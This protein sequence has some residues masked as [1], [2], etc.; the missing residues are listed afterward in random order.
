[1]STCVL[2][3][4]FFCVKLHQLN[5]PHV[6][7]QEQYPVIFGPKRIWFGT[8]VIIVLCQAEFSTSTKL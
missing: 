6:M 3:I 2:H 8:K 5:R 7:G 4:E 1:M